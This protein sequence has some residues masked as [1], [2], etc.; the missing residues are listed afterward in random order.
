MLKVA[1]LVN[2]RYEIFWDS[3][4]SVDFMVCIYSVN[5]SKCL[6]GK[7]SPCVRFSCK[8]R[9]FRKAWCV[10][11]AATGLIPL[12]HTGR[13]TPQSL[14]ELTGY[15]SG[16]GHLETRAIKG[17]DTYSESQ[18]VF[19]FQQRGRINFPPQTLK[20]LPSYFCI[21][22]W[23]SILFPIT[24][25]FFILLLTLSSIEIDISIRAEYQPP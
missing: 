12:Y 23:T 20:F 24:T 19:N 4:Y 5:L 9:K 13:L 6:V 17:R 15:A 3:E 11:A 10:H 22:F 25:Y 16:A 7:L 21:F 2:R 18:I 14:M 8:G 1:E